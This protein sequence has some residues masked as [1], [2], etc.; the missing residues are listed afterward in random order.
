MVKIPDMFMSANWSDEREMADLFTAGLQSGVK[1][2]DTAR[3]YKAEKRVGRALK[4]ALERTATKRDEI[5]IQTRI[6]NEEI[7]KGNIRDEVLRSIDKLGGVIPDCFMFHWPTPDY[8]LAAWHKLEDVY[9]KEKIVGSIGICNCRMR[10]LEFMEKECDLMPHILQVEV[11][12]FWQVTELKA[13]CDRQGIVMQAFSPLCKMIDSI[14]T[15]VTLQNLSD[16]YCVSIPQ[17]IL[18]WNYQRGIKPIS[19][20]HKV[21]RVKSNFNIWGFN[22]TESDMQLI[23]DLD[24]GYKLHLE[25]ATCAGF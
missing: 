7:I 22:L 3:E 2:F 10:H 24:C 5:F 1:G 20:S 12:P 25:S 6:S 18:R 13:Y 17:I 9:L 14:R 8:F 21:E 23:A 19:L 16:K 4:A 15:N 11:T